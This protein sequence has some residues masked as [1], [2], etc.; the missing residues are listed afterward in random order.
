MFGLPS[1]SP[2]SSAL[3]RWQPSTPLLYLLLTTIILGCPIASPGQQDRPTEF[4]VKA[5]YLYNF[6]KF[7]QWPANQNADHGQLE[8]C[9]LGKDPFGPVLDATVAGEKVRGKPINIK[10]LSQPEEIGECN[11][12]YISSSEAPRLRTVLDTAARLGVLTVSDIPRFTEQGGIIGFVT[13]DDRIRF[14]VNRRAA[15]DSHVVLS[16]ELLKVA[17]RV[18]NK[19]AGVAQD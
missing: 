6:G 5:A 3:R 2:S 13:R 8:I 15:E 1:Y 7:A 12:V 4:Q 14:E 16:S 11:I 18:I 19:G 17:I 9:V 10:R